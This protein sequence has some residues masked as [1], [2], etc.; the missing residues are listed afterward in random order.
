ML[1]DSHCHLDFPD[2]ASQREAVLARA[3]GAGVGLM[4]TI[5][6]RVQCFDEVLGIAEAHD[7]VYC[8]VGTHP[9]HHQTSEGGGDRRSR[10]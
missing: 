9:H 6:T 1:I 4:V 8:S 2:L 3:K 7:Q 5:S 10:P